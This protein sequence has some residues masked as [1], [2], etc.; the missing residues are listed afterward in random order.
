MSIYILRCSAAF[1]DLLLVCSGLLL[2]ER[3]TFF[4][5]CPGVVNLLV[6][7]D[8][9]GRI[10]LIVI[11]GF[12]L[13]FISWKIDGKVQLLRLLT[14]HASRAGGNLS[15]ATASFFMT[16]K[17]NFTILDLRMDVGTDERIHHSVN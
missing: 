5:I 4:L 16:I 6:V 17:V 15:S 1:Q 11:I 10:L 9:S 3:N 8:A 14:R 12:K 2:L 13:S 7:V